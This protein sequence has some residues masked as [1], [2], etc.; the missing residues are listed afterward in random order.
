MAKKKTKKAE[1]IIRENPESIFQ[2]VEG[3]KV[4][5]PLSIDYPTEGL[6]NMARKINEVI[7]EING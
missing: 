5:Q 4:I 2:P 3:G 6:N 7:E 1:T